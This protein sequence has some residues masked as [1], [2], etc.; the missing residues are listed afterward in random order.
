MD[1]RLAGAT[2]GPSAGV[3]DC[4]LVQAV[5]NLS[6]PPK[7]ELRAG[8]SINHALTPR[9]QGGRNTHSPAR[10]TTG[11]APCCPKAEGPGRVVCAR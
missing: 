3:M 11:G 4:T 1:A 7:R 8:T 10:K 9:P 5:P 6:S 2:N